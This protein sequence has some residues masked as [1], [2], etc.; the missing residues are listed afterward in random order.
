MKAF[1]TG[2]IEKPST[3]L[4]DLDAWKPGAVVN[5]AATG[6]K[7]EVLKLGN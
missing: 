7:L 6:L 4:T 5:V 2:Q 3:F 1:A